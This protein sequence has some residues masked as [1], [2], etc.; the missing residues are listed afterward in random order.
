[1]WWLRQTE[2]VST[3]MVPTLHEIRTYI[4]D[5]HPVM[6]FPS[7]RLTE[8]ENWASKLSQLWQGVLAKMSCAGVFQ[9]IVLGKNFGPWYPCTT[10]PGLRGTLNFCAK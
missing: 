1:M 2:G 4:S 9:L 10:L 3:E 6:T 5:V 7:V 8:K